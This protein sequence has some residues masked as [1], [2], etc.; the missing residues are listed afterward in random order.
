M[1]TRWQRYLETH[2][3]ASDAALAILLFGVS[4][5]GSILSTT[6][7]SDRPAWWAGVL[8]S[9]VA[10]AALLWQRGRPRTVVAVTTVCAMGTSAMG[11]LLTPLLLGPVM[12]ALYW[13]AAGADRK[14]TRRYTLSV[15]VLVG[16]TALFADPVNHSLLLKTLNPI[17]WI[18]LSA[19]FGS[20][21]QLRR[22]YLAALQSRAAHAE[23]MRIARELHD[24]VAHH[25]TL[26]NAQA[27]TAAHLARTHPDQARQILTELT[28]TTATALRELKA[29][30]GLLRQAND[31]ESSPELEPSP[32]LA[33]LDDLT[34]S[35]ASTGLTV[36]VT[37]HGEP[38]ELSAAV[39]LTA[40]R[41]VQE[42]LTNVSK[43]AHTKTAYVHL[44]YAP[45]GDLTLRI[46]D[47]G[48][49]TVRTAPGHGFGLIGMRER[50]HSVGGHLHTGHRP[51][52]GFEVTAELPSHPRPPEENRT[53]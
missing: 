14:T 29:T 43:H 40:F 5:S 45:E 36:T 20:G 23:R 8:I 30:V 11:F 18:L 42:A 51:E 4:F 10:C 19:M 26:A 21:V 27:G 52:G 9:A 3:R 48:H 15:A 41:I 6:A 25:L 24:V 28:G 2:P 47:D 37:T 44:S 31:A 46:T 13:L 38:R 32:G 1:L 22:A 53:P 7:P 39:D 35:F 17:A 33:R 12:S 16:A 50:A 34:A 49:H